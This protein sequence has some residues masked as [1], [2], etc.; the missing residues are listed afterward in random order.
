[1]QKL[2]ISFKFNKQEKKKKARKEE[3]TQMKQAELHFWILHL[4]FQA[5]LTNSESH[6]IPS[7]YSNQWIIDV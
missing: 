6:L 5:K 2:I 1:M 4:I 7:V 3:R